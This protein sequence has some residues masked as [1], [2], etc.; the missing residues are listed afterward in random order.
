M[1]LFRAI[2]W[3]AT[4]KVNVVLLSY[5]CAN[6]YRNSPILKCTSSV[7]H[8]VEKNNE[9]RSQQSLPVHHLLYEKSVHHNTVPETGLETH[10]QL[11]I[12]HDLIQQNRLLI[13]THNSK[14]NNRTF[15]RQICIAVA[16]KL[17]KKLC[18]SDSGFTIRQCAP[19]KFVYYYYYY[20]QLVHTWKNATKYETSMRHNIN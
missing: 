9:S 17:E 19:Y 3:H 6:Y 15:K 14:Q 10:P 8:G 4:V 5:T 12:H 18:A 2:Y 7:I 13:S 11:W 20:Y 16:C 1:R